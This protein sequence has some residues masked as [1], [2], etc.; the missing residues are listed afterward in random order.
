[1]TK[2]APKETPQK[3]Q[4]VAVFQPTRLPYHDVIGEKFGVDKT[5]WKALVEAV[6]PA[7]KTPDAIVMALS[8]CQARK[9]D[10]FKRPVHIVPMWSAAEGRMIE[11]VWPGIS[12][13]RTT[14][15]R[16]GQYAGKAETE[17]GPLIE[18][19]FEGENHKKEK[20]TVNVT[21]PEWARITVSRMLNGIP[22]V[23]TSPKVYWLETYAKW[24]NT[25]VPNDMWAKR[26]SG[27]LEKCAEAAALRCAFPEEIGNDLTAEEMEGQVILDHARDV[28]PPAIPATTPP[29]IKSIEAEVALPHKKRDDETFDSGEW[30]E[31][32]KVKVDACESVQELTDLQAKEQGAVQDK[33]ATAHWDDSFDY[34]QKAH[35]RLLA[36]G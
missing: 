4:Q 29:P 11:T 8:Y 6:F 12:E 35:D 24:A 28:T 7:A 15:F 17:F 25:E 18:K 13:L 32:F 31:Q 33:V 10:P 36:R 26:P 22:C 23:F 14:A 34:V 27:Q 16:T 9:L 30:L 3:T 19:K 20:K 5:A 2:P 21:F 1:M